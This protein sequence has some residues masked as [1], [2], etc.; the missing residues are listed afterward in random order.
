MASPRGRRRP[1]EL[2]NVRGAVYLPQDAWNAYQ[3]WANYE[4]DVVERDLGYAA[5]LGLDSVRVWS[6]YEYWREGASQLFDRTEHFLSTCR[7]HG[8]RPLIVLF[9]APPKQPPKKSNLRNTDP[10]SAFGVHSPSRPR[11][12]QRRNWDEGDGSPIQ[13]SRWWATSFGEDD[14]LLATEIVNEPGDVRPRRDFAFDALR[15]V[16][17]AAPSATLTMGTKD[18]RYARLYDRDDDLDVYQFHMNLPK[19]PAAA[20]FYL[21]KQRTAA[22]RTDT[23]KPLWCTEWQRTL[24]EPPSR[25]APNLSSLGPTVRGATADG[26]IDGDFFW[27]LMLKPAYLKTPR[28]R[29]RVNG[30]FH[31]DGAVYS[32][33][34][35]AAVATGDATGPEKIASLSGT[36]GGMPAD[37]LSELDVP[38]RHAFPSSWQSHP[39]PYPKVGT[40]DSETAHPTTEFGFADASEP[41]DQSK[42][43]GSRAV[44][45]QGKSNAMTELDSDE[46]SE[47]EAEGE[48]FLNRRE[49]FLSRLLDVLNVRGKR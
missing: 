37:E 13:F 14:R 34:D 31:A 11:I 4:S 49:S 8:I 28:E 3:F 19:D 26:T 7:D 6:S 18:V 15:A 1:T 46:Q 9:E 29:G 27:S 45:Q 33:A 5:R 12:L 48:S 40:N 10:A 44:T 20:K 36:G 47:T 39:F 35:A 17:D 24:E 32:K 30:L 21:E 22:D 41:N 42:S 25:F 38:E 2:S 43:D 16:R 23:D